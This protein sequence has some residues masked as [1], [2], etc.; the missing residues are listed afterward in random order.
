MTGTRISRVLQVLSMIAF[1]PGPVRLK[2]IRERLDLH[3][4][5][6]S[7]IV[8]E[9][10]AAGLIAKCAYRSVT[11]TP[12]LAVMGGAAGKNH[13][14]SSISASVMRRFLAEEELSG[15]FAAAAPGGLWHFYRVTRGTPPP[16]PLWNSDAAAVIFAAGKVP[17]ETILEKLDFAA[18]KEHD[19]AFAAFKE[20]YLEACEKSHLIHFHGGRYRQLTIPVHCG[21]LICA[22]SVAGDF[23]ARQERIYL[24]SFR[25]AAKIRSLYEKLAENDAQS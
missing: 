2:E 3:P 6:V 16:D 18:P 20:R 7:R 24:E 17:W 11:G 12:A 4:S 21:E 25:M 1:N 8:A 23:A 10:I 15:E 5:M 22:L 9:L 19:R 13:P 14:L